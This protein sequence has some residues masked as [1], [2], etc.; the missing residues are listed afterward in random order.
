MPACPQNAVCEH[1]TSAAR[2]RADAAAEA[3]IPG[4]LQGLLLRGAAGG[5]TIR[6]QLLEEEE[7]EA[8]EA[9]QQ[10]L[11]PGRHLQ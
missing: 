1:R 6:W 2:A 8:E 9:R 11:L 5:D 3:A 10:V 4:A 7:E